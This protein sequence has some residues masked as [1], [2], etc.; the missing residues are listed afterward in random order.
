MLTPV[1]DV[2]ERGTQD[3]VVQMGNL[4]AAFRIRSLRP[5]GSDDLNRAVEAY[6]LA[7]TAGLDTAPGRILQL[8]R[9]WAAWA[10]TRQSWAEAAQAADYGLAA[11][12]RLFRAQL[13]SGEKETWLREAVGIPTVAAY[14]AAAA[15]DLRDAVAAFEGGRALILSEILDLD[16]ANVMSLAAA[17]R[18]GLAGR[19]RSAAARWHELSQ[20]QERLDR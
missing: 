3:W 18:D 4:A 10:V 1:V 5:N 14:A 2:T 11:I 15:G 6:R 12:H 7:C 20:R 17:G 13:G 8:G 9:T 19:Y 16:A